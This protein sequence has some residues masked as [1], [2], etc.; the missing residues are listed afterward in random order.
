MQKEYIF[1]ARNN[2]NLF[3]AQ[4]I[5]KKY[6][7]NDGQLSARD[8]RA[9][10]TLYTNLSPRGGGR[11]SGMRSRSGRDAEIEK[12]K[13]IDA[14]RMR[15]GST[16]GSESERI[17]RSSEGT[18]VS[19]SGLGDIG[20]RGEGA[21]Q[22]TETPGPS[23]KKFTG[24][25][26][27]EVQ[28]DN[29]E[30]LDIE[31]KYDWLFS[32]GKP[33]VSGMSPAA[34]E[35]ALKKLIAEEEALEKANTR[36]ARR[37]GA[38]QDRGMASRGRTPSQNATYDWVN[39]LSSPTEKWLEEKNKA[40]LD[41]YKEWKKNLGT[42]TPGGQA[43]EMLRGM[44]SRSGGSGRQ[45]RTMITDEATYFGEIEKNLPV[46]IRKATE[47]K[48]SKISQALSLLQ[49]IIKKQEA[50]KTGSRRTNTG[51]IFVTA[52][53][54]DRILDALM[55]VIDRQVQ[56][57]GNEE[58]I[59][60]FAKLVDKMAQAAM[61]TFVNRDTSEI[62]SRTTKRT[63]SRG[64]EVEIPDAGIGL[65]RG[66]ASSSNLGGYNRRRTQA[67]DKK[68]ED[69]L[70]EEV[71]T[72]LT[73]DQQ[74]RYSKLYEAEMAKYGGAGLALKRQEKKEIHQRIMKEILGQ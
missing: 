68:F 35:G 1:W 56:R 58:R 9:L 61:S 62:G 72:K 6:D 29:W 14:E 15:S 2:P 3:V 52:D 11:R 36:R 25:S 66:M 49:D 48:E 73:P 19:A 32:N 4:R 51:S 23:E 65:P 43:P 33:E 37:A 27:N 13:K 30:S 22:R 67:A 42:I 71:E 18:G 60:A 38:G 34:Y 41:S 63:N 40:T 54:A 53:E 24:K 45:G 55:W 10:D 16:T 17:G 8:W 50:S 69:I 57:N 70:R 21:S 64:K 12:Q 26:F 47:A 44:S 46:E 74:K 5:L 59:S 31:E 39:N 20:I 28:P 7:D